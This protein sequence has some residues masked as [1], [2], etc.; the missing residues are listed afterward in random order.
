MAFICNVSWGCHIFWNYLC[1]CI[2]FLLIILKGLKDA[3]DPSGMTQQ[4]W[5][6]SSIAFTVIINTIVLKLFIETNFWNWLSFGTGAF[7]IILYSATV[8][9]LNTKPVSDVLQPELQNEY[10]LIL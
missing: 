8:L 10:F 2:T 9:L 1:K 5:W 4:H 6:T 3:V 7:C